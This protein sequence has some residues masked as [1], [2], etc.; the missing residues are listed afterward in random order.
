MPIYTLAQS[1]KSKVRFLKRWIYDDHRLC[2]FYLNSDSR[3]DAKKGGAFSTIM[4]E[5]VLNNLRSLSLG[6][7]VALPT[8]GFLFGPGMRSIVFTNE[9]HSHL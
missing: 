8:I 2:N 1:I 4:S 5:R 3:F 9:E 6:R 7:D